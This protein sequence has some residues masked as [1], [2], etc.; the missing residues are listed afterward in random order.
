VGRLQT[1]RPRLE[2]VRVHPA[3]PTQNRGGGRAHLR[4]QARLLR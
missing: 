3:S 2:G 4:R 1:K